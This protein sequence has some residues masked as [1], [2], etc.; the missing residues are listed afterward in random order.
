MINEFPYDSTN[1]N[2]PYLINRNNSKAIIG[3]EGESLTADYIWSVEGQD[4]ENLVHWVFDYYRKKGFPDCE[5]SEE[6]LRKKFN[7]LKK[8]DPDDVINSNGHIKNTSSLG[9]D[10]YK[11]FIW[12]KYYSAKGTGK[13]RS[14]IEVFNDDE[15]LLN[16]IKNRM[17]YCTTKEDGSKRPYIFT[18]SNGMILQGIRST[19]YGYNVS[20]FKPVI[21]KYIYKHYAVKSVLDFSAGWGA[22]SLAA[23][24]LEL[25]YYG[26]D[27][28]TYKEVNN[29]MKFFGGVG[30][31]VGGGSEEKSS[32]KDIPMVDCVMSCP[33]YFDLEIYSNDESQS[34]NRYSDYDDWINIYWWNTVSNCLEK[35]EDNGCFIFVVKDKIKKY[36]LA[37]DMVKVCE[38][39]GLKIEKKIHYKTLNSHLSGKKKTKKIDKNSEA[40]YIMRK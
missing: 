28:L 4:R 10:V 27:P 12:E 21:A 16:V 18:I 30:S 24:S 23:L 7:S 32:Y 9:N 6:E 17:G 38:E 35:L 5:L 11:T 14:V 26:I 22:R 2:N 8:K 25:E 13:S 1:S 19:G 20:L 34:I 33:S 40:V 36:N 31:V 15:L 37:E 3:P 29:M 39:K